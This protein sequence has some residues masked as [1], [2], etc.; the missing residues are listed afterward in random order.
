V[1]NF[2]ELLIWQK[3]REL[4]KVVYSTTEKLP[5]EEKFGLVSQMRRASVSIVSN[6]A[7]GC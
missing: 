6:I 5:F 4:V 3:A 2:K 7:E 1:R